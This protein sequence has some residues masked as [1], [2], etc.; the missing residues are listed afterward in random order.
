M[1]LPAL[2][3]FHHTG[4]GRGDKLA[5]MMKYSLGKA[6]WGTASAGGAVEQSRTGS[7]YAKANNDDNKQK[8][9]RKWVQ[10]KSTNQSLES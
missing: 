10:I 9:S 3:S 6:G 5:Q 4:E 7:Q 8:A 2:G 1:N